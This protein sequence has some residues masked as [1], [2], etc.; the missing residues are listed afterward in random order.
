MQTSSFVQQLQSD[1]EAVAAVG[2]DAVATAARRLSA[3]LGASAGLRLLNA[4]SEVAAELSGQ[5]PS[6][7]IEVRVSGH[8]VELVYVPDEEPTAERPAL[9]EPAAARIT[10]RL[11]EALKA[12]VEEAAA[13]EGLSVNNWIVRSLTRSVAGPPRRVG[14]RLTGF[15]RS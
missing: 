13:R 10:L 8:D 5:I 4:L 1:L 12:S 11:P 14:S 2:D 6:G 15:G 3:A 9:E 7:H